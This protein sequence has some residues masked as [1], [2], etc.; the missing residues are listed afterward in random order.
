MLATVATMQLEDCDSPYDQQVKA[1]LDNFILR[2]LQAG[3]DQKFSK[4]KEASSRDVRNAASSSSKDGVIDL[5]DLQKMAEEQQPELTVITSDMSSSSVTTSMHGSCTSTAS[6]CG[7]DTSQPRRSKK[8]SKRLDKKKRKYRQLLADTGAASAAEDEDN[9]EDDD[10]AVTHTGKSKRR[11]PRKSVSFHGPRAF[12]KSNSP[13]LRDTF[14]RSNS[15]QDLSPNKDTSEDRDKS[16]GKNSNQIKSKTLDGLSAVSTHASSSA[17]P[18]DIGHRV[19]LR[20]AL[21]DLAS[22]IGDSLDSDTTNNEERSPSSSPS[23]SS[24]ARRQQIKRT[25]SNLGAK[26][27]KKNSGVSPVPVRM[28]HRHFNSSAS[29]SMHKK[30]APAISTSMGSR[31]AGSQISNLASA[32]GVTLR[33][34]FSCASTDSTLLCMTQGPLSDE[35]RTDDN[36]D[37]NAADSMK[38]TTCLSCHDAGRMRRGSRRTTPEQN[39]LPS[40]SK[41]LGSGRMKRGSRCTT[42]V[43]FL[44]P[45]KSRSL[46]SVDKREAAAAAAANVASSFDWK[47]YAAGRTADDA[48]N[49]TEGNTTG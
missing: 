8:A 21:S 2:R 36:D 32:A 49:D 30:D 33:S 25:F 7:T 40:K 29:T 15:F 18:K 11:L 17:R 45:P 24:P 27:S 20:R 16:I 31:L 46:S 47:S 22:Q 13:T 9:N 48:D 42:P 39:M 6:G 41:S 3:A 35:S 4:Q 28:P 1:T 37:N 19:K 5:L 34:S 10:V 14:K 43:K 44:L 38:M 12:S 26:N 23:L